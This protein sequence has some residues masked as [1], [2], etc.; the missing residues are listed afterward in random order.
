MTEASRIGSNMVL[1]A[2]RAPAAG[3]AERVERSTPQ[4]ERG[5]PRDIYHLKIQQQ[6][7]HFF[8]FTHITKMFLFF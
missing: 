1:P 7:Q 6:R 3:L 5:V 2:E 8:R 4:K